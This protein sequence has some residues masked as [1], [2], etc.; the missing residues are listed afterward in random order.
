MANRL[1]E[2]VLGPTVLSRHPRSS[3]LEPGAYLTDDTHLYYVVLVSANAESRPLVT[4]EDCG[5]LEQFVCPQRELEQ[6]RL[7]V[8]RGSDE[9]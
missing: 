6:R 9:G 1:Q 7:R 3:Q 5:T 4:V 8:V 2:M